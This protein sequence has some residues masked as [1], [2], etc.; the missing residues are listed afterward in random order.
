[1]EGPQK[2]Y[3][4]DQL[5]R[6]LLGLKNEEFLLNSGTY[7]AKEPSHHPVEFALLH[8]GDFEIRLLPFVPRGQAYGFSNL[9]FLFAKWPVLC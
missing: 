4:N 6:D 2:G 5:T 8:Q 1:M 9:V 3:F 7:G